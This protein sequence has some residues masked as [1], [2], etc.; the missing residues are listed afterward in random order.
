MLAATPKQI[1]LIKSKGL[2]FDSFQRLRRIWQVQLKRIN[3][4]Q[5]L[6]VS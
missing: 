1:A 3:H 6:K 5:T 4:K 2:E